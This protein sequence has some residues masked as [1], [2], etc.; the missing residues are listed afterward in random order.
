MPYYKLLKQFMP[1]GVENGDPE[2]AEGNSYVDILPD[3]GDVSNDKIDVYDDITKA[4]KD[5]K[6]KEDADKEK[7]PDDKDKV[8]KYGK[9]IKYRKYK[10]VEITFEEYDQKK[11]KV[12]IKKDAK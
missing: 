10:I 6:D 9:K 12:I 5:K 1:V 3:G 11:P 7:K 4:D 2:W 8:D